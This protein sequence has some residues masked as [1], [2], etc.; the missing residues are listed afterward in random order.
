MSRWQLNDRGEPTTDVVVPSWLDVPDSIA[1][2]TM[3]RK[4]PGVSWHARLGIHIIVLNELLGDARQA[5]VLARQLADA[6]DEL[7]TERASHEQT[8][9]ML[10]LVRA[11]RDAAAIV[12]DSARELVD[13]VALDGGG[14][15]ERTGKALD[16]VRDALGR[17]DILESA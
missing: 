6:N 17:L 9:E 5:N 13:A 3:L 8:R 7:D 4:A 2:H 15:D 10:A 11:H 1:G 12:A 16:D 14:V